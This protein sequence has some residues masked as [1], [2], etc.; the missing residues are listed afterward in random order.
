VTNLLIDVAAQALS[1]LVLALLTS[2]ARR[3]FQ[4]GPVPA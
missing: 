1:A 3:V 2:L 4:A